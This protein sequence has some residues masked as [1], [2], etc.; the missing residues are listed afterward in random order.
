MKFFVSLVVITLALP[1]LAD[2]IVTDRPGNG[3]GPA[4]V[5]PGTVQIETSANYSLDDLAG[6][7]QT[8]SFPTVMRVGLSERAELRVGHSFLNFGNG[9]A[10]FSDLVVG[11]KVAFT[12]MPAIGMTLDVALPT[13][14]AG[15]SGG[16]IQADWRL[17]TSLPLS[18]SFGLLVNLGLDTPPS[19]GGLLADRDLRGN[20]VL[21]LGWS[22]PLDGLSVFA[23]VFGQVA[24]TDATPVLQADAGATYLI[25]DDVQL[26]FFTQHALTDQSSPFQ[27]AAGL[28]FRF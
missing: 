20:F 6:P 21:N 22:T 19:E 28:S 17:I 4:V 8:I 26:D 27:I 7:S 10:G 12:D 15:F 3:N 9:G 2:S 18:D 13:G 1:A 14:Q 25:T 16:L 5:A 24:F 23:E 11:T